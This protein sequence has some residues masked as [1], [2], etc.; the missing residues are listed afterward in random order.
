MNTTHVLLDAAYK[1]RNLRGH[2]LLNVVYLQT[3][4]SDWS[5]LEKR[6]FEKNL[7]EAIGFLEKEALKENVSLRFSVKSE[8]LSNGTPS[9]APPNIDKTLAKA[10]GYDSASGY[11]N[12]LKRIF[13]ADAIV[14][15]FSLP[16]L[17]WRAY[18]CGTYIVVDKKSR[19]HTLLHEI[20]HTFGA[21]DY[22]LPARVKKLAEEGEYFPH[23]V[24]LSGWDIRPDSIDSLTRHLIGWHQKPDAAAQ[25]F[26]DQ[27]RDL[28]FSQIETAKIVSRNTLVNVFQRS[29]PYTSFE[30]IQKAAARRDPWA[31]FL[32]ARCHE[33]GIYT[34]K[35]P[36]KAEEFYWHAWGGDCASAGYRLA[37]MKLSQNCLIESDKVVVRHILAALTDRPHHIL[38]TS[39]YACCLYTGFGLERNLSE[40]RK[41]ISRHVFFYNH[42][43][44][45][46]YSQF[47][48]IPKTVQQHKLLER[49]SQGLPELN[50]SIKELT[51]K[52][53]II[54]K[55]GD[56]V[57]FFL[58]G[59][60][61]SDESHSEPDFTRVFELNLKA[62]QDGL[63]A[64]CAAV[65]D[66][67]SSGKGMSANPSA[68]TR[69]RDEAAKA[70]LKEDSDPET[71][72]HVRI[73]NSML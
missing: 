68:A 43:G 11:E 47:R 65:A 10:H 29:V 24:M 41:L 51:E 25:S 35:D 34:E 20:L 23:S 3:S 14:T 15:V 21:R 40:A 17:L 33:K 2:V 22:Y 53:A 18:A 1:N 57:L 5:A 12:E 52:Y 56:E 16:G 73:L 36:L 59:K 39:L 60:I 45:N 7:R 44:Q 62:A 49:L 28:T 58:M 8:D 69:W 54:E 13:A 4:A 67:Y 6:G 42:S 32:L 48:R 31:C 19:P 26:L 55:R 66:L 38:A 50:A 61:L 9:E 63:S 30:A 37:V 27:T 72:P 71:R 46:E 64:A 70:R